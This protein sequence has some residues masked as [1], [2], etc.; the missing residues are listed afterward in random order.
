MTRPLMTWGD[1]STVYSEKGFREAMRTH[2]NLERTGELIHNYWL[3]AQAIA[4]Q[5]IG[6][7][8]PIVEYTEEQ[9]ERHQAM[10]VP[11]SELSRDDQIKDLYIAY[12][13]DKEWFVKQTGHKEVF[14]EFPRVITWETVS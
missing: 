9:A 11:Y 7:E 14:A 2:C 5:N 3:Q 13:L 1:F 6:L 8:N 12:K 4:E 10:K